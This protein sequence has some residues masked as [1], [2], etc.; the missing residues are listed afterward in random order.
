VIAHIVGRSAIAAGIALLGATAP[1][2]AG[3]QSEA[4]TTWAA[5]H[6]IPLT[7]IEPG[8]D[9]RD[10]APVHAIVGSA[11]VVAIGEPMHGAHEPLAFRNR[12]IEYLIQH[13]GF[14]AVALESGFSES[15]LVD[16]YIAGG[17]G[18]A[19]SVARDGITW[20]FGVFKDNI[21]LVEWLRAWNANP[22]HVRKVRFYGLDLGGGANAT[23][24]YPRRGIDSVLAYLSHAD[25]GI[26]RVAHAALDPYLGRFSAQGYDSLST[27]DRM[28]LA[29]GLALL[30]ADM[31]R[32]RRRL[33]N[34][35]TED[36][37]AWM[38]RRVVDGQQ[39]QQYLDLTPPPPSPGTRRDPSRQIQARDSAQ[40][41]NVK[42]ALEREGSAG[43]LVIFA[44]N[45]HVMNSLMELG[46][47]SSVKQSTAAMGT[48][49]R[50][51]L[52]RD[53][54]IIGGTSGG[55]PPAANDSA[56]VD[57]ALSK[58]GVP[59]FL[60]DLRSAD[61]AALR[62]L[63]EPHT[64]RSNNRVQIITARS[65]FDAVYYVDRLTSGRP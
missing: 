11:R 40:A 44:H 23:F 47:E 17:P 60:L 12:L 45:G 53:L 33:V 36:E 15:R 56:E 34:A 28:E 54:V 52:G 4:V 1:R 38:L 25:S 24:P 26:S 65:A 35:T 9:A 27:H 41:E 2:I 5:A 30:I 7:T 50:S 37:Y 13:E 21:A 10:L 22:K 14:T 46:P 55:L 19:A 61:G 18:D 3:G 16:R 49:L 51:A 42:W 32:E 57:G 63:S 6:A 8:G 62:W 20:G 48:F 59:R 31:T 43:K 39:M 58:V 64:T 29:A